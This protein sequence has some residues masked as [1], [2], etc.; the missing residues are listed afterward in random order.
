[1]SNTPQHESLSRVERMELKGKE[2]EKDE[3]G[4]TV[5]KVKKRI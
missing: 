1:L 3:K 4:E 2:T 5:E